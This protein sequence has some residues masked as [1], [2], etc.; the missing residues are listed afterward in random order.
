MNN[1]QKKNVIA[2]KVLQG[3]VKS[4]KQKQTV[5]VGVESLSRHRL[6]KKAVKR[7]RRFA[8][9]VDGM[10]LAVG[11]VVLMREIKPISKTKHFLVYEKVSK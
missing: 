9:H 1:D 6:Y 11:D 10:E 2:G 7:T 4:V 3:E 8:A 5:I